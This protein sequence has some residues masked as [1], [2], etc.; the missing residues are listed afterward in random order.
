MSLARAHTITAEIVGNVLSVA[1][2][3]GARVL[4]G[5]TIVILESMK[6]EIPVL[7]EY[8]GVVRDVAVQVG[9]VVQEGDVLAVVDPV[10]A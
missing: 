2:D 7:T 10:P 8:D 4:A 9:D 3:E 6:M 1:V 5:D